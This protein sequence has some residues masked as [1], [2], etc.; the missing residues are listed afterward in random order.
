[1]SRKHL[2]KLLGYCYTVLTPSANSCCSS[3]LSPQSL[4]LK[5]LNFYRQVSQSITQFS[6]HDVGLRRALSPLLRKLDDVSWT[7]LPSNQRILEK[8]KIYKE[9]LVEVEELQSLKL[10]TTEFIFNRI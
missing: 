10:G 7:Q 8:L 6:E 9:K 4:S 3:F 5:R 2:S 1:M